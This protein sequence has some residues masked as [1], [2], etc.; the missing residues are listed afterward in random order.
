VDVTVV[1]VPDLGRSR[2]CPISLGEPSRACASAGGLESHVVEVFRPLENLRG[3]GPCLDLVA[4]SAVWEGMSRRV[5]IGI[6]YLRCL[7]SL[8]LGG[9][10]LG[11]GPRY[12]NWVGEKGDL[13]PDAFPS[14]MRG[15]CAGEPFRIGGGGGTILPPYPRR[16]SVPRTLRKT[17]S[18][19]A[20]VDSSRQDRRNAWTHEPG[21]RLG[22]GQPPVG[23]PADM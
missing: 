5:R 10:V 2:R 13:P 18:R 8:A 23:L 14:A 6:R 11:P 19:L 7:A 4:I 21:V 20:T 15:R 16:R 3:S 1:A 12:I 17:S 22:R 9:E